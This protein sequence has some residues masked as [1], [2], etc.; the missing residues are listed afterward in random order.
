MA[1]RETSGEVADHG[2]IVDELSTIIPGSVAWIGRFRE[3][4]ACYENGPTKTQLDRLI[5]LFRAVFYMDTT[6]STDLSEFDSC[7][8]DMAQDL[9]L[10]Q[11][12]VSTSSDI[13]DAERRA[14]LC[15]LRVPS[16]S[17]PSLIPLEAIFHLWARLR[18]RR[19]PGRPKKTGFELEDEPFVEIGLE[20]LRLKMARSSRHAA[21]KV[22][23]QYGRNPPRPDGLRGAS[24]E[25]IIDRLQKRIRRRW[26]AE[27]VF[28][29][30]IRRKNNSL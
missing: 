27:R 26:K 2:S 30:E 8:K 25:S 22:F 5:I 28:P 21:M 10:Y 12:A 4:L 23:D 1:K 18:P 16:F 14:V 13:D 7:R 15:L 9:I 11:K 19:G 29:Q 24:P 20:Y 6:K 3:A 17:H